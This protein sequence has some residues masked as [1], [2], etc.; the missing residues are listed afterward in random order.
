MEISFLNKNLYFCGY[1]NS[2]N[3]EKTLP[4]DNPL[5][6]D[7]SVIYNYSKN[8]IK[9]LYYGGFT[10]P[11]NSYYDKNAPENFGVEKIYSKLSCSGTDS[12]NTEMILDLISNG[13]LSSE[14]LYYFDENAK[15]S[16]SVN[17]DLDRLYDVYIKDGD[18]ENAF[19][20][21]FQTL[22]EA[23]DIETGEVCHIKGNKNISIKTSD[24]KIQELFITPET[25]LKLFPP[26][27]R[28]IIRQ[29]NVGDCY[30]L[31]T[32]DAVYQNENTRFKILEMFKENPD[33][34]I[35]TAFG[36]FKRNE[37]NEIVLKNKNNFILENIDKY[38]EKFKSKGISPTAKWVMAIQLLNGAERN[39]AQYG[40]DISNIDLKKSS[41]GHACEILR[42]MGFRRPLSDFPH[43]DRM[44]EMLFDDNNSNS[45]FIGSTFL[46]ADNDTKKFEPKHSYSIVP[47]DNEG[48]GKF[49][50]RNPYNTV[51]EIILTYPEI[52]KYFEKITAASKN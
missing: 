8:K 36:G 32:L 26:V 40:D 33:G 21:E 6:N 10:I 43:S 47:L 1:K 45:V 41:E 37:N 13:K 9:N 2:K 29:S 11:L 7:D 28:F 52:I 24:G 3:Q 44:E 20:P 42:K 34:S 48:C 35:D 51:F 18:I 14:V 22:S 46:K 30:L 31:S 27:E 25:Y 5:Q 39:M 38:I 49:A 16:T 4:S 19:V 23:E 17:D 50:V 12:S 15:I